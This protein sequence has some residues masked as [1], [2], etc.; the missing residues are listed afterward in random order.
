M[1][2]QNH[3]TNLLQEV[4]LKGSKLSPRG[5]N[6]SEKINTILEL[7][8]V[9][10]C[11]DLPGRNFNWKYLAAELLWYLSGDRKT[12]DIGKYAKLWIEISDENGEITSNYGNLVLDKVLPDGKTQ[13]EFCLHELIKDKDTR[14]ALIRYNSNEH[15]YEA[16]KDKPCTISN[17]FMIRDNKLHCIVNMRSNDL[18]YGFQ[19]DFAWF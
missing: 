9:E 7:E 5:K 6:I 10:L 4:F 8:P 15:A 13:Y 14:Q 1:S 3:Y 19:Y 2:N 11:F 18:F 12:A 17:Q 16:N